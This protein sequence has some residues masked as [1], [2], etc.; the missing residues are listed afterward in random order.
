MKYIRGGVAGVGARVKE[1]D[2]VQQLSVAFLSKEN[3]ETK[4]ICAELLSVSPGS[5]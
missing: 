3:T 1:L 5:F 2:F 4:M